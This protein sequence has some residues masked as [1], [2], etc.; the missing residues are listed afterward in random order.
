[1]VKPRSPPKPSKEVLACKP[2]LHPKHS[3]GVLVGKP[4]LPPKPSKEV[5]AGKPPLPKKPSAV[6][7]EAE[8]S[9]LP[10]GW[11]KSCVRVYEQV[12]LANEH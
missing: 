10:V 12:S 7:Q 9:T 6:S 11:V 1:M 5:L 2:S 3:K 8:G 4:P